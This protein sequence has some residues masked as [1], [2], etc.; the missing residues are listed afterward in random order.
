MTEEMLK[1]EYEQ[2]LAALRNK[3]NNCNHTWGE[4]KYDPEI[5]QEPRYEMK[6]QG[7][8]CY[9][10]VV[11]YTECKKDR[12]SRTCVNCGKVEYTYTQKPIQ[13]AP[14]FD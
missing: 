5:I 14:D 7:S 8:D 1:K 3:Q 4:T 12:W 6:F 2:K 9:H 10:E 11:G 13:Y